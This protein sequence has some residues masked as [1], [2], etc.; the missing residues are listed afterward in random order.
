MIIDV[1]KLR[2][3]QLTETVS[4]LKEKQ[5]RYDQEPERMRISGVS[6]KNTDATKESDS[7]D[8]SKSLTEIV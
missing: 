8:V 1:L 6:K 5:E 2:N 4:S 7:D 3:Q